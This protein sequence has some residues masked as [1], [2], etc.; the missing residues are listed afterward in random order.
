MIKIE[1][2]WKFQKIHL[3]FCVGEN[4]EPMLA[5]NV[6]D[7]KSWSEIWVIGDKFGDAK[8]FYLIVETKILVT[9]SIN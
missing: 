6:G 5:M 8:I 3:N 9:N 7:V 2:S 1:T 4:V